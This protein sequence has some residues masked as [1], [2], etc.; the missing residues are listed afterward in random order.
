MVSQAYHTSDVV[1]QVEAVYHDE[2]ED[3]EQPEVRNLTENEEQSE[4][5]QAS[6]D[7]DDNRGEGMEVSR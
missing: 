2:A 4:D 3:Q 6:A 5:Y 1:V 7:N